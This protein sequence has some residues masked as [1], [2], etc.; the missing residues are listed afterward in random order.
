MGR[1]TYPRNSEGVEFKPG[2]WIM[3]GD[4]KVK[5]LGVSQDMLFY[6]GDGPLTSIHVSKARPAA[7]PVDPVEKVREF[8]EAVAGSPDMFD[9]LASRLLD[10]LGVNREN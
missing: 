3:V 7:A 4:A 9:S 2:D 8:S 10:E 6:Q 1:M 5:V